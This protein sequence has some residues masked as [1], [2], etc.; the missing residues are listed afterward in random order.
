ML[1]IKT[2][3]LVLWYACAHWSPVRTRVAN[4]HVCPSLPH[5]ELVCEELLF[6]RESVLPPSLVLDDQVREQLPVRMLVPTG[7]NTARG[8]LT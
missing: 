2:S 3:K 6:E 1:H 7:G 8:H 4:W 5:Q